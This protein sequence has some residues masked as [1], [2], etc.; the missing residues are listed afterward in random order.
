LVWPG[1]DWAIRANIRVEKFAQR[2][3]GPHLGEFRMNL[4]NQPPIF[5]HEAYRAEIEKLSKAALMDIVWDLAQRCAGETDDRPWQI[6]EEIQRTA[7]VIM[8]YRMQARKS[9]EGT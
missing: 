2:V 7:D 6:M 1:F 8:T 9:K 4:K 5:V 3:E